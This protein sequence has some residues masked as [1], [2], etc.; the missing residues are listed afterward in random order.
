MVVQRILLISRLFESRM[1]SNVCFTTMEPKTLIE[2]RK[3]LCFDSWLQRY[4]SIGTLE[5]VYRTKPGCGIAFKPC[6]SSGKALSIFREMWVFRRRRKCNIRLK[7]IFGRAPMC[8]LCLYIRRSVHSNYQM[9]H[10]N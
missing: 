4:C 9:E 10:R 2:N 3:S 1:Y 7:E 8:L 6:T 5:D